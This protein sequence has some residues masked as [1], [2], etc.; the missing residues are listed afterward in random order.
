MRL[1]IPTGRMF[2]VVRELLADAGIAI[3]ANGKDY[4]P[5]VSDERFEV[6]LL[7]AAN[8]AKL[9]EFGAHDVGFCGVDWI[10]ESSADIDIVLDTGLL[11]VRVVVAGTAGCDPF[12]ASL[13]RPLIAASEYESLTCRY[14]ASRGVEYRFVRTYGATEVFPPEDADVI[15]DNVATGRTL[16]ANG[17]E[18]IDE[19]LTSSTVLVANRAAMADSG[20]RAVIEELSMLLKSVLDARSRVLLDM[21]VAADRLAAVVAMLPAMRSPTVQPLHADGGFAVRAAV[22]RDAV[23]RLLPGLRRAGAMD[24]L[25]SEIQRV[26]V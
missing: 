19:I 8:I 14:L 11:P 26:L 12:N 17:L 21:N 9:V 13:G 3:R 15:V 4:R 18:V 16:S 23:G 24:I 10:R 22:P 2:D 25:Q 5:A 7:K 1:V 6:K 20:K